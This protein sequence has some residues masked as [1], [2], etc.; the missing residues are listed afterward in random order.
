MRSSHYNEDVFISSSFE[1]LDWG[2]KTDDIYM[3]CI[4]KSLD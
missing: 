3:I 4:L 1:V 2:S